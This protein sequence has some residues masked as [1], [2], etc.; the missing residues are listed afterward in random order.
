MV[1]E[2]AKDDAYRIAVAYAWSGDHD[3]AFA[4]LDRAFAQHDVGMLSLKFDPFLRGL[5]DDPRYAAL[6]RKLKFP[7]P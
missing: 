3:Q 2:H 6:L 4:W 5:R 1:A 7:E